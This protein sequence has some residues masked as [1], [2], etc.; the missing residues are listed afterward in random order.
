MN[1]LGLLGIVL[2]TATAGAETP[3]EKAYWNGQLTY[4]ARS[5]ESASKVCGVDLGFEWVNKP[6]LRA[7]ADKTD[8]TPAGICTNIVDYVDMVCRS[9]PDEKA[10]VRARVARIRCGYSKSRTLRLERGVL[11]YMGNNVEA[12]FLDWAKILLKMM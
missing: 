5:I 7:E 12:N 1:K 9:G 10:A 8:H 3:E 11:T 2:A 6:T 4:I